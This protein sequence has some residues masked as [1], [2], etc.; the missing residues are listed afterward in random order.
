MLEEYITGL[1]K[2][3]KPPKTIISYQNDIL[4]FM[5]DLHIQ[6]DHFVTATDVR[7]WIISCYIQMME[8][9][10]RSPRLIVD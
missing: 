9:L 8:K 10:S 7:K 2:Q 4:I 1:E 6:P 3:N 5:N